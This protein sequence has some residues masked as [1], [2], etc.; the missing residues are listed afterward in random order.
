MGLVGPARQGGQL[1]AELD[2]TNSSVSQPSGK[3]DKRGFGYLEVNTCRG[4]QSWW[5]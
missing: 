5:W 3:W 4:K 2:T 1:A